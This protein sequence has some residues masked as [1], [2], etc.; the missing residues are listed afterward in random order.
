MDMRCA[1]STL[2]AV[3]G[4]GKVNRTSPAPCEEAVN[5]PAGTS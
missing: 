1:S 4:T 2:G 5:R 3:D